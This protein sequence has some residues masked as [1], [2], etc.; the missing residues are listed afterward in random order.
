MV[1]RKSNSYFSLISIIVFAQP[2]SS[3]NQLMPSGSSTS[4]TAA[5]ST[6]TR[7]ISMAS[8]LSSK[9]HRKKPSDGG[10]ESGFK[11]RLQTIRS[12][13][14]DTTTTAET[15]SE[16]RIASDVVLLCRLV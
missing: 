10:E 15:P 2:S 9:T 5:P 3:K 13:N 1:R 14:S 4:I 12:R 8:V 16:D 7:N 11:S 6:F